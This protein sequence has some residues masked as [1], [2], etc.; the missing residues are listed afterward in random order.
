MILAMIELDDRWSSSR[1]L[2]LLLERDDDDDDALLLPWVVVMLLVDARGWTCA[3]I[4]LQL[5]RGEI[6]GYCSDRKTGSEQSEKV[7]HC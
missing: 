5:Q 3:V 7:N 1:G 6:E 2:L 4:L